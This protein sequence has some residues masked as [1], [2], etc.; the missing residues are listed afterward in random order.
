[1]QFQPES[2]EAIKSLVARIKIGALFPAIESI[3]SKLLAFFSYFKYKAVPSFSDSIVLS[4]LLKQESC[5]SI[6]E[7]QSRPS[8][9][10]LI[11][12]LSQECQISS[13]SELQ[14]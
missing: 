5:R 4:H 2:I 3:L 8:R 9:R 10:E 11:E 7:P 13:G 14:N 1:M 12:S 6:S